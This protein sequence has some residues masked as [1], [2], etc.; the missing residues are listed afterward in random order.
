MIDHLILIAPGGRVVFAGSPRKLREHFT[1]FGYAPTSHCNMADFMMDCLAGFVLPSGSARH[2]DVNSAIKALC[3][4]WQENKENTASQKPTLRGKPRK[5]TVVHNRGNEWCST[6]F[7]R[8]FNVAFA[9]QKKTYYRTFHVIAETCLLLI[10]SGVAVGFLLGSVRLVNFTQPTMITQTITGQLVFG[11]FTTS[12]GLKLFGNDCH[13]RLREIEGGVWLLPMFMGKVAA[14]YVEYAFYPFAFLAG[15]YSVIRSNAVFECYWATFF[16]LHCALFGLANFVSILVPGKIKDLV[17][18]GLLV[19]LWLFGGVQPP[20]PDLETAFPVLGP[21]LN[22]I[23]P[24]R[25]SFQL[26]TIVEFNGHSQIWKPVIQG[27]YEKFGFNHNY[28]YDGG[29]LLV[30][31]FIANLLAYCALSTKRNNFLS[32]ILCYARTNKRLRSLTGASESKPKGRPREL[33][34]ASDGAIMYAQQQLQHQKP[35]QHHPIETVDTFDSGD[36][37]DVEVVCGVVIREP[38]EQVV[39]DEDRMYHPHFEKHFSGS[40]YDAV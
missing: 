38:P 31:A 29:M 23:S 10:I 21:L 40:Q 12:S 30:Y 8:T 5:T 13:M 27:V 4:W 32:V 9:R 20:E 34:V 18:L 28:L 33:N 7:Y 2:T 37:G 17:M 14:S 1:R 6:V 16:L 25:W 3:D 19:V 24:F 39:R 11:I 22:Y 35:H 36:V 26:A 15:Y